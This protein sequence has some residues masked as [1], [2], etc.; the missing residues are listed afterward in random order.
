MATYKYLRYEAVDE[1]A[2]VRIVLDRP[3]SR[4]AQ[5]RGLLTELGDAFERA[6]QDDSVRVVILAGSGSVFSSGHD[7]GSAE[8]RQEREP[9]P[10]QHPSYQVNSGTRL[11]AERRMVQE[12]HHYFQN[13]LRWRNLRKITIA[14]VQG[15]VYAAGL[16]LMWACDL[17]VAAEGTLFA[18]PVGPRLGGAGVEYF[19]HPWEL[20]PR[21]AKE[22]LLT[23]DGIDAADA[24]RIGMV[25][26]VFPAAELTERCLAFARRIAALPTIAALM[27][28][29]S[30]NQSVDAQGFQV[31]LTACFSLHHVLHAHWAE[32]HG[33]DLPLATEQDGIR[34]WRTAPP[35]SLAQKSSPGL[36][37][38]PS[39]SRSPSPA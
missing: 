35:V 11:A 7:L 24:Y 21:R 22:L 39:S 9:G 15:S 25:N 36:S 6:E 3:D 17:I 19:A 16:M 5:N 13:T 2:I 26:K 23:G 29:E 10:S 33:S 27:V 38:C 34:N 32:L 1:G 12:W 4:N 20:G 28:K 18:D 37:L 14:E 8:A 31:A 30:V